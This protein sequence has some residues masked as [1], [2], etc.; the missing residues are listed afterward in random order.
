MKC[1]KNFEKIL[2]KLQIKFWIDPRKII[3]K[4]REKRIF[5]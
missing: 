4:L 5:F 1:F 3:E 2:E